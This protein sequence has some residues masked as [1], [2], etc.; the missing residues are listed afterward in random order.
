MKKIIF[1]TGN[2]NKVKEIHELLNH[3]Y[4]VLS[5]SDIGFSGVLTEPFDTLEAN[6]QTKAT[7]LFEQIG[8]NCFAEDS[9]L[10]VPALNDAPGVYSARYS[11]EN[12][13]DATNIELLLQQLENTTERS[14]YFKTVI[15]LIYEGKHYQFDGTCYG[16]IIDKPRGTNGFGYDPIFIADELPNKTFA[17]IS[18][19]DK[20]RISHRAKA[21][22]KFIDFLKHQG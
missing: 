2:A 8:Q 20:N 5:L 12:A 18:R 7:Q 6:A 11:G 19:E 4:E 13:T 9:G 15:H 10:F 3:N 14:A 22:F 17:E 16:K 21:T 1:A